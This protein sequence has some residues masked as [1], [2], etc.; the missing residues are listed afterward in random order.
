MLI[1]REL[2]ESSVEISQMNSLKRSKPAKGGAVLRGGIYE[3][4]G[5]IYHQKRRGKVIDGSATSVIDP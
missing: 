5:L 1:A 3:P 4:H 2:A